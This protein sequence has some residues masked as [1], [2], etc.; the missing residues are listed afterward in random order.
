LIEDDYAPIPRT[1]DSTTFGA[2]DMRGAA[3]KSSTKRQI[4]TSDSDPDADALR[5][6]APHL[7]SRA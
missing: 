4:L 3:P 1:F 6:G 2:I 7:S 5:I